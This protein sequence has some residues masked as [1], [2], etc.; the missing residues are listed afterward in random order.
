MK[1]IIIV[2]PNRYTGYSYITYAKTFLPGYNL[3]GL[4]TTSQLYTVFKSDATSHLNEILMAEGNTYEELVDTLKSR[5]PVCFMVGDDS[6]FILADRLQYDFFP[7][8]SNDISLY[9]KRISKN[10]YLEYLYQKNLI[11]TKQY[12]VSSDNIPELDFNQSYVLKPINGA[13][14]EN[15]F[16]V[17]SMDTIKNVLKTHNDSFVLQEYIE[18]EEYCMEMVSFRGIHKCTMA[19]IYK[20]NYLVDGTSPWREENE[21]VSQNDPNVKIIYEYVSE[22]LFTLGI[23]VGMSWTQVKISN[24]IPH[25]IEINFR[26]QGHGIFQYIQKATG[27]NYATESFKSY[28]RRDNLDITNLMYKKIGDWNKIC[29]NNIRERHVESVPWDELLEIK[30][31]IYV[32]QYATLPNVIP[33]SRNFR[34]TIGMIM[35]QNTDRT[36]YLIDYQRIKKWKS[37]IEQ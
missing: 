22:I 30:S 10:N 35:L 29:V 18:G 4:W 25:L 14:N 19:S 6:A 23:K 26:S 1:S 13:G 36:Q 31:D 2:N 21:L 3:I 12:N 15:V 24:G 27:S 11:T 33:V 20:G 5:N 9:E 34:T 37:K 7:D 16:V 17:K 28:L 8:N 32:Q